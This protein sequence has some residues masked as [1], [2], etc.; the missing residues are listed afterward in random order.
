[1]QVSFIV[2]IANIRNRDAVHLSAM[3]EWKNFAEREN[4]TRCR[5]DKTQLFHKKSEQFTNHVYIYICFF[6]IFHKSYN[7]QKLNQF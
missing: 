7:I 6:Y 3:E 1:M 2:D 5:E 4:G